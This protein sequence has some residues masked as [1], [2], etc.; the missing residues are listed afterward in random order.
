MILKAFRLRIFIF[1]TKIFQLSYDECVFFNLFFASNLRMCPN[2]LPETIIGFLKFTRIS[3]FTPT[4]GL[5]VFQSKK[6]SR[7]FKL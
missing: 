3:S 4:L 1:I 5:L 6:Q 7:P 2:F